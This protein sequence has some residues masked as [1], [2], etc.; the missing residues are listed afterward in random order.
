MNCSNKITTAELSRFIFNNALYGEN[1]QKYKDVLLTRQQN[2]VI[3]PG[4]SYIEN[5]CKNA[6]DKKNCYAQ[7]I[8]HM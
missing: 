8:I 3:P 7:T 6:C 1:Y 5:V 2:L 4:G